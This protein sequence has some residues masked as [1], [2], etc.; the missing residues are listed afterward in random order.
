MAK[1]IGA[2]VVIA[3]DSHQL[4]HLDYMRFGVGQ[5]RRGWLEPGDIANTRS[6]KELKKL[7]KRG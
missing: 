4:D 2:K 5:A 1:D 7:L 6:I 3:T